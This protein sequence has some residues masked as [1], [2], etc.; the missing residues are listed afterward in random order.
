MEYPTRRQVLASGAGGVVFG[1]VASTP[2]V[3]SEV[4]EGRTVYVGASVSSGPGR[5][6]ALD[7]TTGSEIWAIETEYMGSIRSSPTVVDGTVYFG[8]KRDLYA[9][10]AT[11]G[12]VEWTFDLESGVSRCAPTVMGE[13]VFIGDTDGHVYAVDAEEGT[14]YWR[15]DTG[16]RIARAPH[17][18]NET[19]YA[20]SSDGSL[21]AL[22]AHSGEREWSTDLMG[23]GNVSSSPT[24][25]NERVF[26]A[27]R[28]NV[29]AVDAADGRV[30]WEFVKGEFLRSRSSP[31]VVGGTV[32]IGGRESDGDLH[33]P[34][35]YAI[36]A[37]SGTEEWSVP[38]EDEVA[39]GA[40]TVA[41]G[42]VIVG[43]TSVTKDTIEAYN[44]V[45]GEK[46]WGF[47]ANSVAYSPTVRDG[48][49]Y[50]PSS[51]GLYGLSLSSGSE[52]FL[53]G[54]RPRSA[55]TVVD[56]PESGHS[57][58]TRVSLGTQG[59]HHAWSG[60]DP[61]ADYRDDVISG[62]IT[63][64]D[65]TP[66]SGVDVEISDPD[67]NEV[68]ATT[69]TDDDGVFS[70]ELFTDT[71]LIIVDNE[72]F[73]RFDREVDLGAGGIDVDI[74]LVGQE[75]IR[76]DAELWT[77]SDNPGRYRGAPTI[78]DDVVYTA[79]DDGRLVAL[80]RD[81]GEEIWTR[82]RGGAGDIAPTVVDG[83]LYYAPSGMEALDAETGDVEWDYETD[84]SILAPPTVVGG[85]VYAGTG[86][87]GDHAL[88]ALDAE[89]G[90]EEWTLDVDAP[91]VSAPTVG[92]ETV[93]VG[94]EDENLYA[95]DAQSG[96]QQWRFEVGGEVESSATVS[97]G[98]AYVGSREGYL[99][100]VDTETGDQ[101]WGY[102]TH[103]LTNSTPTVWNGTVFVGSFGGQHAVDAAT[104]ERVWEVENDDGFATSSTV[105]GGVLFAP[106][107]DGSLYALDPETGDELWRF[108]AG[109][110][111]LTSPTVADGV[112]YFGADNTIF[113]AVDAD[114]EGSSEGT[115]IMQGTLGHHEGWLHAG[116]MSTGAGEG[117]G[118]QDQ[119]SDDVAN[120]AEDAELDAS[121]GQTDTAE[122]A[123]DGLPGFGVGG[124]LTGLGGVGYLLKR[125]L[126]DEETE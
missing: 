74:E 70:A 10:D 46:S 83:T 116:Q 59:H 109:D 2:A 97:D 32:Y 12:D 8:S 38:L 80:E 53:A 64:S 26:A 87:R 33:Y 4:A 89:D 84:A 119:D 86:G 101:E 85:T 57:V 61:G 117:S 91:L 40:P 11:T 9:V 54:I 24:A 126:S 82:H 7:A 94:S 100:A 113:F 47:E 120:D 66:L 72:G 48:I 105:A 6:V 25:I 112:V 31:T 1:S 23:S 95:V 60:G 17:V 111:V 34:H 98:L 88:V 62:T 118:S 77:F 22:D 36:D 28:N 110:S 99:Y 55:P 90:E 13:L 58:D 44:T 56:D 125:Q 115:R 19:V 37:E 51:N 29:Y 5:M 69:V 96:D 15:Y 104:G 21:Y 67:T 43:N 79:D 16:R 14:E 39:R 65:G 3:G 42:A 92:D 103:S 49:V 63:D 78:V 52:L 76:H 93:Y 45:T 68:E 20:G 122:E 35:L 50:V 18:R 123:D 114:V 106:S 108:E 30:E 27:G 124:A 81:S 75:E 71:Y 73:D 41:N 102:E 107:R 121:D